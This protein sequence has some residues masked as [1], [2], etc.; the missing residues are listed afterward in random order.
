MAGESTRRVP[1]RLGHL[2][3]RTI[4]RTDGGST[5]V[6][7][8]SMFVDTHTFDPLIPHLSEVRRLVLID[9]PG[10]GGSDPLTR[11]TSLGETV[12]A[13]RD[14]FRA[15]GFEEPV[16]F[17]GNAFGGHIGYQLA[18]EP[19]LLRSLVA[20]SAP[21]EANPPHIIRQTKTLLPLIW[22]VGRR[23]LLRP[24]SAKML[25]PESA[26]DPEVWRIFRSGFLTPTRRSMANAVRSFVLPRPDVRGQL[27][28][29][30]VPALYVASDQ[31][32]EW[33]P[34]SAEEAAALT[35]G[36]EAAVVSGAST[37]VPLEQPAELARLI[38]GYWDRVGR[39][40]RDGDPPPVGQT[41]RT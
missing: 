28:D 14:A 10:L 34:R 32:G 12:G 38:P 25:A 11:L 31:R 15:L 2:L 36:A 23:P 40:D 6:L 37:L 30:K 19:G 13:V 21:P 8:P 26:R 20:V 9:G 27:G 16:D 41:R 5:A 33:T 35:P 4:D 22:L 39:T 7:M 29:I 17:V 1:T 3:V 24:L 18:R